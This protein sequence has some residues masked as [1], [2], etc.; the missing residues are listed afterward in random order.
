MRRCDLHLPRAISLLAL[1]TVLLS[2]V[3]CGDDIEPTG[4][5]PDTDIEADEWGYNVPFESGSQID[6]DVL[7]GLQVHLPCY[8]QITAI[9]VI[10]F[11][12]AAPDELTTF[13]L[14]ADAGGEPGTSIARTSPAGVSLIQGKQRVPLLIPEVL[15]PGT[16]WIMLDATA[17]WGIG[18]PIGQDPGLPFLN[19]R[20]YYCDFP[21][22]PM[23]YDLTGLTHDYSLSALNLYLVGYSTYCP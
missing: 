6:T 18:S 23:P 10:G 8:A 17:P 19:Y 4:F 20:F 2:A 12:P 16:Y 5:A 15:A 13:A 11:V 1:L 3:S 9:G 21:C 14:Y 7:L 22:D